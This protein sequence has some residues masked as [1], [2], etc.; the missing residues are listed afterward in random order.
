MEFPTEAA[1]GRHD[2]ATLSHW[3]GRDEYE[4]VV[5]EGSAEN[6]EVERTMGVGLSPRTDASL[7]VSMG[8]ISGVLCGA[9]S[10]RSL[11]PPGVSLWS[12]DSGDEPETPGSPHVDTALLEKEPPR[13]LQTNGE[14]Q[15]QPLS[16]SSAPSLMMDLS[17][18]ETSL[19]E[20]VGTVKDWLKKV[21][22][23]RDRLRKDKAALT[24]QLR[25]ER[26][27]RAQLQA[28]VEELGANKERL[29]AGLG[30]ELL[31]VRTALAEEKEALEDRAQSEQKSWQKQLERL[32]EKNASL[33]EALV[34][35]K[36]SSTL[37]EANKL[38]EA[39]K[40]HFEKLTGTIQELEERFARDMKE[41]SAAKAEELEIEKEA[42]AETMGELHAAKDEKERAA[43]ELEARE[44]ELE[45]LQAE[46][47]RCGAKLEEAAANAHQAE[48]FDLRKEAESTR[49]ALQ[50]MNVEAAEMADQLESSTQELVEMQTK[51]DECETE[52]K[53]ER[54]RGLR[55][56]FEREREKERERRRKEDEE[57][58]Q[59]RKDRDQ[60]DRG[61]DRDKDR[62]DRDRRDGGSD[63]P[64]QAKHWKE[65]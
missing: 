21:K 40:E 52:R 57:R 16:P 53:K 7:A 36:S 54:E 38:E 60:K 6:V 48:L 1:Y 18:L 5:R 12:S 22:A 62:K 51:L 20:E 24:E 33:E 31:E 58:A 15:S 46:H 10:P 17:D 35:E 50:D 25:A 9:V 4:D 34:K 65:L 59:R 63:K 44:R 27:G 26:Q 37:R 32:K 64:I 11:N 49:A 13:Q 19:N 43:K 29:A 2:P 42:H 41:M 39:R 8:G 28:A 30:R 61:R 47:E 23:E 56:N 55:K 14:P 45:R 3:D